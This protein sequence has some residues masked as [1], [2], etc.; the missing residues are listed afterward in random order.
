MSSCLCVCMYLRVCLCTERTF[1]NSEHESNFSMNLRLNSA[2]VWPQAD[3]QMF[4]S[5]TEH[6]TSICTAIWTNKRKTMRDR[7]KRSHH[8]SSIKTAASI[9][10]VEFVSKWSIKSNEL[11]TIPVVNH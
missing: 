7:I 2:A 11:L 4:S 1:I 3:V 6:V 5:M 9:R 8:C 10:Q